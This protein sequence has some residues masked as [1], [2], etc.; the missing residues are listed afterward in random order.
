[1]SA[2]PPSSRGQPAGS[3]ARRWLQAVLGL[4]V[5]AGAIFIAWAL[6]ATKPST[7]RKPREREATVVDVVAVSAAERQLTVEGSGTVVAAHTVDLRPEVTGRVRAIGRDLVPGSIVEEGALIAQLDAR[8]LQIAVTRAKS[9]LARARAALAIERGSQGIAKR[10]LETFEKEHPDRKREDK[11]LALRKPQLDTA[12]ADVAEAKA[13][14]AQARLDASRARITAPFNAILRNRAVTVGS[15]V[16]PT[17][18]LANLVGT[19]TWWIEVAIPKDQ[20]RWLERNEAKV[21]VFDEAAWGKGVSRQARLLRVTSEVVEGGRMVK[22][23]VAVD[24]PLSLRTKDA[25]KMLLGSWAR[26][27]IEGGQVSAVSLDRQLLRDGDA[28]WVMDA[29]DKLD[30]RSVVVG[31]RG[32]DS[33]YVIEGLSDGDR[34]VS[35]SLRPVPGMRLKVRE[36]KPTEA[37]R[38]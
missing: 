9:A 22:V 37:R 25:P 3:Q 35:T 23:V 2:A 31:A 15:Y 13:A 26:V 21:R 5:L 32:R 8:D 19:G 34:V 28:V 11:S 10:E 27:Q 6:I 1:M 16:T 7:R 20:V 36:T 14:L 12:L 18:V 33:V 30:V 38:P 4:A 17:T 29:D 24:D